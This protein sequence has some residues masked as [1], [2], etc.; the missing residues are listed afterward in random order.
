MIRK[1]IKNLKTDARSLRTFGLLIGG[2]FAVLGALLWRRHLPA[3]PWL[4]APGA[5]LV[6][7]GVLAP[8]SL[9][10]VYVGWMCI[11][12]VL[13]FVMS[14]VLLTLFYFLGVTLI[15]LLARL[16]GKDFLEQKPSPQATTYWQPRRQTAPKAPADY[17]RQF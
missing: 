4:F 10:H 13:G 15:G 3:G 7:L 2:I 11:A 1:Q 6:V 9:K 17:E 12:F 16:M 8:R 14:L 5:A